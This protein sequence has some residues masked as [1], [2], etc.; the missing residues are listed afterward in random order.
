MYQAYERKD[1][2]LINRRKR[3]VVQRGKKTQRDVIARIRVLFRSGYS[4]NEIA[5]FLDKEYPQ[6]SIQLR[7]I[8]NYVKEIRDNGLP[9]DR[10]AMNGDDARRVLDVLAF[11]I[12]FTNGRKRTFSADDAEWVAWVYRA[13]PGLSL[14]RIWTLASLYLAEERRKSPDMSPLDAFMAFRPWE[15]KENE[16]A[17]FEA[18]PPEDRITFI[19]DAAGSMTEKA[20]LTAAAEVVSTRGEGNP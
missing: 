6:G 7:T 5:D 11:V 20:S 4:T 17:Y 2:P 10:T 19:I 18:V 1:S 13:A 8:Q 9:W 15:N 12:R 3:K 16:T 14:Y